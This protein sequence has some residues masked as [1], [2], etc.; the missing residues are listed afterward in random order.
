MKNKVFGIGLQKTGT[1]T[2]G[3]SLKKLGYRGTTYDWN[4]TKSFFE[5]NI[6]PLFAVADKYDSFEDW[7][8]PLA[9]KEL[10]E[11]YPNSKF[12]LTR[13]KSAEIWFE[14]LKRHADRYDV[15]KYRKLIYGHEMPH[16]HKDEHIAF[17]QAHNQAVREYFSSRPTDFIEVCWEEG[18]GWVELC[19]FL[20]I[21]D[22]PNKPFL[23]LNRSSKSENSIISRF[24]KKF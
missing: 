12:I 18:D 5:G 13:R 6:E 19:S 17:Y 23:H 11:R 10:D 24:K 9:F 14:S 20:N 16:Q 4:L 7:P 15:T 8:W 3:V 2:L 21:D 22:I 1:T